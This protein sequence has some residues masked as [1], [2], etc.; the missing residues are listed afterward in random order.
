MQF[1]LNKTTT[2]A[3]FQ[4]LTA[5]AS[6]AEAGRKFSLRDRNDDNDTW[7]GSSFAEAMQRAAAGDM[8]RVSR[9]DRL[10]DRI[11]A[12]LDLSS[13]RRLSTPSVAGGSPN[14]V[15]Y[16]AGSPLSMRS[17]RPVMSDRGEVVIFANLFISASF[18]LSV[19]ERR[20]AALLALVRAVSQIRPIT[21]YVTGVADNG[22][23]R[24][25]Q[26]VK[27]DTAPLD[28]ARAAWALSAPEA[29][30][31]IAICAN[32]QIGGEYDMWRAADDTKTEAAL[33]AALG[34]SDFVTTP[35]LVSKVGKSPFDT[36]ESAAAWVQGQLATLSGAD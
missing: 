10:L 6:A 4:T 22:D 1:A 7:A 32:H 3:V 19:Y 13:L 21:L 36:D 8:S 31:H 25:I 17:R 28:L 11:E 9:A 14:V 12:G 23:R 30:R 35:A 15:A 26:A 27:I 34:V 5:W 24:K 16:L 2:A 33:A 18:N 20:G 29:F